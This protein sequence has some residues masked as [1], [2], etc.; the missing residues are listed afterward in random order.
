MTKKSMTPR[1]T[2]PVILFFGGLEFLTNFQTDLLF[3]VDPLAFFRA[4]FHG[5]ITYLQVWLC[6][7]GSAGVAGVFRVS[8]ILAVG[9][10]VVDVWWLVFPSGTSGIAN[11]PTA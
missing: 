5:D 9:V 11:Y 8:G 10:T 3:L 4:E 1:M 2:F 7:G 6:K